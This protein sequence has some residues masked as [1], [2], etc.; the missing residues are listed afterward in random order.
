MTLASRSVLSGLAVLCITSCS[1]ANSGAETTTVFAAASLVDAFTELGEAFESAHPDSDIE[2][3]FASS[4]DLAT[5]IIEG[6]QADIFA[7]ADTKN[8]DKVRESPV[9]IRDVRTFAT[10]SLEI[11]VE[12]GNPMNIDELSDLSKPN[13]IFITCDESVPIGRYSADILSRAHVTVIPKSYEESVKG[14][15]NKIVL[16]EADAGIV[17][18]T[19]VIASGTAAQGVTIPS[20]FNVVAE[21]PITL[22]GNTSSTSARSFLDFVTTSET[23]RKILE[24]YGFGPP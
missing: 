3:N 11:L 22:I 4:S 18:R 14:I 23:A 17:Y 10:N 2:F 7:S 21:Y 19:D 1:P 15:V 13:L 8:V 5:Q 24:S 16:G 6:A 20:E 12:A 9:P